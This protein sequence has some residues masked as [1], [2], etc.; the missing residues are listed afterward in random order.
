MVW[1]TS[2]YVFRWHLDPFGRDDEDHGDE[3]DDY[4]QDDKYD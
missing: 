3:C 2:F 1:R 4:E